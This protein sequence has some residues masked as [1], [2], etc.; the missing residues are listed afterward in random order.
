MPAHVMISRLIDELQDCR[1]HITLLQH[2]IGT[3]KHR[4]RLTDLDKAWDASA[5]R[6]VLLMGFT[7]LTLVVY[8]HALGIKS[9]WQNAVVPAAGFMLSMLSMPSVKSIWLHIFFKDQ[10][11]EISACPAPASPGTNEEVCSPL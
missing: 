10:L 11:M 9:A 8:L 6:A 3:L 5:I 4:N 1:S 2:E 7:Y